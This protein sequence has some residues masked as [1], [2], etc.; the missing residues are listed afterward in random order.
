MGG[1]GCDTLVR[2]LAS[3][4]ECSCAVLLC[5]VCGVYFAMVCSADSRLMVF[6]NLAYSSFF[7]SPSCAVSASFCAVRDAAYRHTRT[8]TSTTSSSSIAV[9]WHMCVNLSS[10]CI[11]S[12]WRG[13]A[14]PRARAR[15]RARARTCCVLSSFCLSAYASASSLDTSKNTSPTRILHTHKHKAQATQHRSNK[16]QHRSNTEATAHNTHNDSRRPHAQ[17]GRWEHHHLPHAHESLVEFDPSV[18]CCA[19]SLCCALRLWCF[20]ASVCACVC[21]GACVAC[22]A[23]SC[24]CNCCNSNNM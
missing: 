5:A 14:L 22:V 7:S 4:C 15:A 1:A 16:T 8:R 23:A 24:A 18:A 2:T 10:F 11:C 20:C 9:E 21:C 19:V 17:V 6:P 3:G 13:C 12:C